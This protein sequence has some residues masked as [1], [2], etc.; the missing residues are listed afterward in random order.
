MTIEIDPR[1][2]IVVVLSLLAVGFCTGYGIA[3][4]ER[5]RRYQRRYYK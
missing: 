2:L 4:K 1:V 3:A 5:R